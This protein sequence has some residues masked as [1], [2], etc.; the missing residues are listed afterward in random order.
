M[1]NKN[2]GKEPQEVS[3]LKALL[4]SLFGVIKHYDYQQD[5]P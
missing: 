5:K 1:Y 2:I 3:S 4:N